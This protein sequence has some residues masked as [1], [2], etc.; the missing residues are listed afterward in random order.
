MSK[1]PYI[2]RIEQCRIEG[3][4]NISKKSGCCHHHLR[5][6]MA[7]FSDG[8]QCQTITPDTHMQRWLQALQ[9]YQEVIN[10]I[11]A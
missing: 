4:K 7:I 2:D 9:R 5:G 6:V 11:D 3:C 10:N 1:N 8:E